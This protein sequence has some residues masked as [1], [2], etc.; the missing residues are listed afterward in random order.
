MWLI[1]HLKEILLLLLKNISHE[2]THRHSGIAANLQWL[3][4]II[5]GFEICFQAV[6]QI[7]VV[8]EVVSPISIW[9]ELL[10]NE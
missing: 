3:S 1:H 10:S 4:T 8:K 7:E 6:K 5:L 9:S 2:K